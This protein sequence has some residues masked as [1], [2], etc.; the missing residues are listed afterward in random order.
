MIRSGS[1]NGGRRGFIVL[2]ALALLMQLLV[3]QGFMVRADAADPG[4]VICTGHGAFVVADRRHPVKAPKPGG[5]APC[6]FAAHGATAPQ[7]PVVVATLSFVAAPQAA[8]LRLR[9]LAPGRGLA[10]PPPPSHG[11][12]AFLI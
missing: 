2:A 6:G 1:T 4:L 3:P 8:L 12:P 11:P 5:D 7:P 10:A 9:D